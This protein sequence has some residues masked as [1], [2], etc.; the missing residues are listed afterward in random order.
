MQMRPP[1]I[2]LLCLLSASGEL[3]VFWVTTN[4]YSIITHTH[5]TVQHRCVHKMPNLGHLCYA[6]L[7]CSVT[8]QL[9]PAKLEPARHKHK[10][11]LKGSKHNH[12]GPGA[13]RGLGGP[14]EPL[15]P[16]QHADVGVQA[17]KS[18]S[19]QPQATAQCGQGKIAYV[20]CWLDSK[21]YVSGVAFE[22]TE[23]TVAPSLCDT[24]GESQEGGF[25]YDGETILEIISCRYGITARGRAWSG[26]CCCCC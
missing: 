12:G 25:L 26:M 23:G 18:S 6:G 8:G 21:G 24:R 4:Q 20:K 16:Q 22:D 5:T 7:L 11:S 9:E 1:C 19:S 2:I 15:V 17:V 10:A 14:T 3:E 13:V